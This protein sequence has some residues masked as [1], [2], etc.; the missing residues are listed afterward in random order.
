MGSFA[1]AAQRINYD[2]GFGDLAKLIAENKAKKDQEEI[3]NQIGEAYK[4]YIGQQ[5]AVDFGLRPGGTVT[6]PFMP[7]DIKNNGMNLL[8]KVMQNPAAREEIINQQNLQ[9]P[10]IP[11]RQTFSP[12]ELYQKSQDV[13][14]KYQN[15]IANLLASPKLTPEHTERI[16][17]LNTIAKSF[18]DK[19]KPQE[20]ML[21]EFD[22]GKDIYDARTGKLIRE[23]VSD[24]TKTGKT[25]EDFQTVIEKGRP[26]LKAFNSKLQKWENIGEVPKEPKP[27]SS[28]LAYRIQKD[29]EKMSKEEKQRQWEYNNIMGSD[30]LY[31][32]EIEA[33]A[34]NGK[35]YLVEQGLVKKTTNPEGSV[36]YRP[37]YGGAYYYVD[38]K[39]RGRLFK[40]NEALEKFA[41][42]QVFNVPNAWTR[43]KQNKE[44]KE[45]TQP[46]KKFEEGATYVDQNGNK[47][48]YRNGEWEEI[49]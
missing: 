10:T 21:K 19:R 1:K 34:E 43:T 24:A 36:S 2:L 26:V 48:I 37:I 5:N 33:L 17:A 6:N 14:S 15:D 27:I 49:E 8:G 3:Y 29:M 38:D 45:A 22:R 20:P 32:D 9:P 13:Y 4:N 31:L 16:N 35:D 47:A 30:Y 46:L 42:S 28:E 12:D 44:D 7:Q 39:G 40:T 23:G 41:K 25:Y 18:V 11:E